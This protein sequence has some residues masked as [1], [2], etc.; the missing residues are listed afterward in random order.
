MNHQDYDVIDVEE[1]AKADRAVPPHKTGQR[2]RI[3][4]DK[5]HYVVAGPTITGREILALAGKTPDRYRLDQKLR[6]GQT[7]KVEPDQIIDL[8]VDG[9][10][11]FMTLPLDQTEGEVAE[12]AAFQQLEMR[13][14]FSLPE[15]DEEY[16]DATGCAWELT[17]VTEG[18]TRVL[19]L[20]IHEYALPEGYVARDG[21]SRSVTRAV[22]VTGY[23]GGAL[24]MVYFSPPIGRADGV[25]IGGLSELKIEGKTF[26]QWSR[27]YSGANPFQV[28]VHN[29]STHLAAADEWLLRELRK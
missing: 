12:S 2:Y 19:W 5:T 4:V 10:E 23:P 14:D 25:G 3:R 29:I 15:E 6:G 27:H 18:G 9:V 7:Q 1:Y 13:R 17:V 20:F 28:G 26:Q 22:R 24:D 8:R 11:K 16:L 21:A